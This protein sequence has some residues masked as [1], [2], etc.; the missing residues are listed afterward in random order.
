MQMGGQCDDVRYARTSLLLT[1]AL[2]SKLLLLE[3]TL[4]QKPFFSIVICIYAKDM[5]EQ[6]HLQKLAHLLKLQQNSLDKQFCLKDNFPEI[7][8][9]VCVCI[10]CETI[11]FRAQYFHPQKMRK[12]STTRSLD[13][14]SHSAL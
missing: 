3:I 5:Y 8:Q 12:I 14:I 2:K 10:F 4:Q 11:L 13:K 6:T 7:L 9:I 1:E